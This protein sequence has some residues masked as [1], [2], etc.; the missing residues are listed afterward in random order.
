MG[1][2]QW[3]KRFGDH[4]APGAYLRVIRP[5]AVTA[6]D[7]LVLVHRPGHG[8]TVADTFVHKQ[9]EAMTRLL[10]AAHTHALDLNPALRTAARRAVARA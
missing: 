2:R 5:G 7:P 9:P 1:E 4:G 6:G 10:K 8:V 3:V